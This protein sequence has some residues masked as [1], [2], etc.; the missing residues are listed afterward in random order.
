MGTSWVGLVY[1]PLTWAGTQPCV[2]PGATTGIGLAYEECAFGR[3]PFLGVSSLDLG[4][5]PRGGAASFI[6][7]AGM[8]DD[9]HTRLL[10]ALLTAFI[11]LNELP[12]PRHVGRVLLAAAVAGKSCS[13][14]AVGTRR[15]AR[16]V[17]W[18]RETVECYLASG[19]W[20]T[21]RVA[22]RPGMLDEHAGWFAEK[23]TRHQMLIPAGVT[24]YKS[25]DVPFLQSLS[26]T[27]PWRAAASG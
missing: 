18:D 4:R 2:C 26:G 21:C 25:Y 13:D 27:L 19:R 7:D 24:H 5:S 22:K 14:D 3:M 20:G 9:D 11:E 6:G 1:G 10:R 16:E 12:H 17:G 23:S 15:I 8:P